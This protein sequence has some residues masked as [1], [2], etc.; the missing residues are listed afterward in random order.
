V[1]MLAAIMFAIFLE[2]VTFVGTCFKSDADFLDGD[3]EAV[4]NA[5]LLCCLFQ[6]SSI[7]IL[8][9]WYQRI[10]RK[11]CV[12]RIHRA[13]SGEKGMRPDLIFLHLFSKFIIRAML[14]RSSLFIPH[15]NVFL[16]Q[17]VS[18]NSS[19]HSMRRC[20]ARLASRRAR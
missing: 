4:F 6:I 7:F 8:P 17:Q 20:R 10:E 3:G 13:A 5:T 19:M 1:K 16:E 14:S 12:R 15:R 2:V 11:T 18:C 9:S